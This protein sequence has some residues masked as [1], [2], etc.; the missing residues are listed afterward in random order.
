MNLSKFQIIAF[1]VLFCLF[2]LLT[3]FL[4]YPVSLLAKSNS[5]IS[6]VNP[7]RGGDFWESETE[8]PYTAVL[9]Q[10]GILNR[11]NVNATWL[12]RYDALADKD[13]IEALKKSPDEKGLF[14][15]IT[16][17]WTKATQVEY[18]KGGNWHAAG[19]AFLTGYEAEERKKLIDGAFSRFNEVFGFYPQ[20]VGAWWIDSYSLDY[21][22]KKYAVS[23]ALIVADQYST[24]NYQIWGQYFSTPYYPSKINALHPAQTRQN[25]LP[26]V[27]TQWAARDPVNGYGN[28]V[29]E[30]TYS[31]QAN[32]YIDFHN[33]DTKYFLKLIDIYTNQSL[34]NFSHLVVGLENSYSWQ[35]YA[36]EYENQIKVLFDKRSAGLVTLVTMSD[37]ASWYKVNFPDLSPEQIIIADDPLGTYKKAVWF[38]NQYYRAGWFLNQEGSL[39]RDIRQYVDGSEELCLK[40]RCDSVNFATTATRVLD[41]VSFG[42]KWLIDEG[43]VTDFKVA[44]NGQN[45]VISY[46]N[47]G[48][49]SRTI[50]FLPRDIEIDDKIFSIDGAILN[51]TGQQAEQQK[52]SIRIEKGTFEW[53]LGTVFVKVI[54]FILFLSLS[55]VIPGFLVIGKV[56]K[57]RSLY[58]VLFLST[59]IGLVEMTLL[60]YIFSLLKIR[61]LIYPYLL[62]NLIL[63]LKFYIPNS[64]RINIPKVKQRLDLAN[65]TLISLGTVFQVIP[66]FKNGL[67]YPFGQGFWGPNTHDGVWHISLIN[68]LLK[69]VPP[70]NPIFS[71]EILKNYHFFYDLL[72]AATAYLVSIPVIDL[73]F[74]FYPVL[75]SLSLGI[76]TYYLISNLFEER[77]GRINTKIATLFSLYL[78]YFAGSFGW[79]VSYIKEQKFAG[80]SAFWANQS[81]S[82]NLNPP[83]AVSLIIIIA[84]VQLLILP[85]KKLIILAI[86]LAGSLIGFKSY[87]AALV[88][89]ALLAVGIL[90]RS[91]KHL[92][93]FTG[94]LVFSSLIFFSNFQLNTQL[95][96]FS[97]FWFIHSMIDS[98]D[99]VGWMRLTLARTVGVEQGIWWKF[100]TAEILSLVI[101]ILGNLGIRFLSLLSL[102][103]IKSI[104]KDNN[105]LFLF[106]LSC[107]SIMIPILFIQA[108]NPWNTIQFLYYGLYVTAVIGGVVFLSITSRLP[109]FISAL[110]VILFLGVTP[111]NSLVT[112][113]YYISY[114]P[115]AR[116]DKNELEALE[117]LSK[118]KDGVVLTYPYDN[119]LKNKIAE[120]WPL[121]A[122]DSTSYVSALANKAV[123]LQDEGQNQ[124]LLTDYKKRVVASKDFFRD[125]I[126]NL[127]SS[128]DLQAAKDFLLYNNIDYIY[129]LNKFSMGI[130]E[131][132]LPIDRIYQNEE[133]TIYQTKY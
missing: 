133:V 78:V 104:V 42:H 121:F 105:H 58:Q 10:M 122:Y 74:R 108:G 110:V 45:Y 93:V 38:M 124:I 123:Y 132:K 101:F 15:E 82:F 59:V 8:Y 3:V 24:D 88:L 22:Q 120:P 62:I 33:L 60:F 9:G 115:H 21:M 119:K 89:S 111:I 39:F 48:G 31:V 7:V 109:K 13:I 14:L 11:L 57:N 96:S 1:K 79:I 127:S 92:T 77:L 55:C 75:F 113:S 16:P 47:E 131:D 49:N 26:V 4:I 128:E 28:G 70:E 71:G 117:F 116:V 86:I 106:I 126:P 43:R 95:F 98:P 17:S 84:L 65:L 76:G 29:S 40:V 27:I 51:A 61:F 118:Q 35:K 20:S 90:K 129:L 94:A 97:P 25:K 73:V 18:H 69:S 56:F 91:L 100:I 63:F 81:I 80:E 102:I 12:I 6:I 72:V 46:K 114:L 34:T 66:T 112:A 41:E 64:K 87:G 30:S 54:K 37:F 44:K 36:K 23:A 125:I 68:Q 32:D 19:S 85:N 83:F 2:F 5:Y 103:K 50:K 53:S 130:D 52:I 107:L 67:V 99:R